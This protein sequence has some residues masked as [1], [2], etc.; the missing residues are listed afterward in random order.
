MEGLGPVLHVDVSGSLDFLEEGLLVRI[1]RSSLLHD[2]NLDEGWLRTEECGLVEATAI[3]GTMMMTTM[4]ML[5]MMTVSMVRMMG[6][7]R[8]MGMVLAV[9][10]SVMVVMARLVES[11]LI[12]GLGLLGGM[13]RAWLKGLLLPVL[14]DLFLVFFRK[15][16]LVDDLSEL[17]LLPIDYGNLDNLGT[18]LGMGCDSRDAADSRK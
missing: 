13:H 5:A 12:E 9:T 1:D 8:V 18:G 15:L 6:M 16:C 7:M 10:M 14:L 17:I 3:T 11:L 2:D 4:T